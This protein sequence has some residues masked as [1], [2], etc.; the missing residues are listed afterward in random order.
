MEK[1]CTRRK[2]QS[3]ADGRIRELDRDMFEI[4]G[5]T[6]SER[7]ASL[8]SK[9]R[10]KMY[11]TR[12]TGVRP[13]GIFTWRPFKIWRVASRLPG[14]FPVRPTIHC[15]TGKVRSGKAFTVLNVV[16]GRKRRA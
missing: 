5:P 8:N 4:P 2:A 6:L 10:R 16:A 14:Q 11:R 12:R 7:R 1:L 15:T 3:S 13:H 9:H